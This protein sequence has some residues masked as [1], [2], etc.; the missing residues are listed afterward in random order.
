MTEHRSLIRRWLAYEREVNAARFWTETQTGE[1]AEV[2]ISFPYPDVVRLR[3][4][5]DR[6]GP[7]R[8]RLLVADGLP[9]FGFTFAADAQGLTLSTPFLHVRV[10]RDP[11]QVRVTDGQ[12]RLLFVQRTDDVTIAGQPEIT[13]FGWETDPQ[14]GRRLHEAFALTPDEK[15]YGFGERFVPINQRGLRFVAW[16][17]DTHSTSSQRSYKP[18]PFFLSNRGW[19]LLIHSTARIHF[20]LG[21]R[22]TISAG[23]GVEDEELDYFLIGGARPP[24]LLRRYWDLT[25]T[26]PV[27]PKWS[28]GFWSSRCSY[29]SR[30]EV[31][32]IAAEYR[33]RGIPCDVI[34]LDPYW[35]GPPGRW[36]TLTWDEE[37]FPNPAEMIARLRQQGFRLSLWENPYIP[38]GTP[39]YEEGAAAGYF[40]CDE[41]GEPYL[42][43]GWAEGMPPLAVVDF[44]NPEAAAWWQEKHR[45]LLAQGVAVFKTDFGESA[46]AGG[47]YHDGT[48]GEQV[49]NLYPLFYNR[50]VFQVVDEAS[51]GRG[52]VWARAA[53]AGSQRYP[54]HWG[55]DS[56]ATFD[57]MAASLRGGLNLILSGFA[58][59]SHD[60]GGFIHESDPALYVRWAQLG[61]FS[62]HAR[63]HGTTPREPWAFDEEVEAI[64]RRYVRLRYRLLPYIYSCAARTAETGRPLMRPLLL[65]YPDDP[66]THTLDL[67]YLFG[68]AFLVAPVF[69]PEADVPVYLPRGNWIDYWTKAVHA[70]PGWITRHAPL[71]LLPLFVREGAIIPMGPEMDYVDQK[72]L[73]PLTLDLY[74]AGEGHFL[75]L[76][77][78]APPVE[79]AYQMN[80]DA[81]ELTVEGYTGQVEVL[82]HGLP[83]PWEVRVNG[84]PLAAWDYRDGQA[85]LT[86]PTEKRGELTVRF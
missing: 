79:I 48:P 78:E 33:R 41:G 45:P 14:G 75:L 10:A 57:H 1:E 9:A 34:H 60:I 49:H 64:F 6:L 54:V 23:F 62:S 7:P 68:D 4:A 70:G 24:D 86:F 30:A 44:T 73:D 58:Y 8:N 83:E 77:E 61:L 53:T 81:L 65:D 5:P 18:V 51:Q 31:E 28:F 52:M 13:T 37:A 67:E 46:P 72:P 21:Y 40:V 35:M 50:T 32:E 47:R 71:D 39:L 80:H 16:T 76:D 56:R 84:A 26:P 2:E 3:M 38:Y 22:S 19:A 43:P 29:R 85:T 42:I 69:A 59:W 15:L 11:W 63:A 27:P 36:C 82:I 20:D 66:T 74:P 55:G 12:G 17:T 25:G